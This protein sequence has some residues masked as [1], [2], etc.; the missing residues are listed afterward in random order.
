V[1]DDMQFAAAFA[2]A[3]PGEAALVDLFFNLQ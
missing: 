3:H 1:W 2:A